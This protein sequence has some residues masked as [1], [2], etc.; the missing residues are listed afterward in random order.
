MERMPVAPISQCSARSPVGQEASGQEGA[1]MT[2]EN[3]AERIEEQRV[4]IYRAMNFV[5]TTQLSLNLRSDRSPDSVDDLSRSGTLDAAYE[6]LDSV[7]MELNA[8]SGK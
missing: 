3:F 5:R 7:A 2:I 6:I 4:L 8:I 1:V